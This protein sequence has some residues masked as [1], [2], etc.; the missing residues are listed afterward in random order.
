MTVMAL[1]A[2][3]VVLGALTQAPRRGGR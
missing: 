1:L 3:A 2:A